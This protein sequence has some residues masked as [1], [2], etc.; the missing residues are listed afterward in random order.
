M[1]NECRSRVVPIRKTFQTGSDGLPARK[2][3]TNYSCRRAKQVES[4]RGNQRTMVSIQAALSFESIFLES[5]ARSL[6]KPTALLLGMDVFS[7]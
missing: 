7:P 1:W 4:F 6:V 5:G 3:E 2:T